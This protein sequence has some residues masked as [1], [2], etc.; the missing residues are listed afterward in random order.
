[1]SSNH[2]HGGRVHP[3]PRNQNTQDTATPPDLNRANTVQRIS[4][5]PEH[6]EGIAITVDHAEKQKTRNDHRNRLKRMVAWCEQE[7][8]DE[9]HLFIRDVTQEELNDKSKHFHK[10]RRDFIYAVLDPGVIMAF[11]STVRKENG[12]GK[13][14]SHSHIRKFHD[15]VLFGAREQGVT[16]SDD[17][18]RDIETYLKSFRLI[19]MVSVYVFVSDENFSCATNKNEDMDIAFKSY[20]AKFVFE[21]QHVQ[22]FSISF[23][24]TQSVKQSHL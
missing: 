22:P 18:Y 13:T 16:M 17:Y 3:G 23:T 9:K 7:Y 24:M 11:L 10:Q 4:I 14:R 2:P 12:T 15:A 8:D 1:M 5:R 20:L 6:A 21:A 19:L